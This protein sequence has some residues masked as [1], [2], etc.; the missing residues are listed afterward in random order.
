MDPIQAL[1]DGVLWPAVLAGV[2]ALVLR[3]LWR[4]EPSWP[5]A[6]GVAIAAAFALAFTLILGWPAFLP[7]DV[8]QVVPYVAVALGAVGFLARGRGL[9]TA[10]IGIATGLYLAWP[11]ADAGAIALHTGLVAATFVVLERGLDRV[12]TTLAPR[13]ANA[14]SL[15]VVSGAALAILFSD[16]ASL[17]QTTGA[18][19]AGLGALFTLGLWRPAAADITRAAP[20][21]AGVLATNLWST[22]LYANGRPEVIALIALAPWVV[23]LLVR[24]SGPRLVA[25]I[26]PALIVTVPIAIAATIAGMRYFAEPTPVEAAPATPGAKA[27]DYDPSY[28]Y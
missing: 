23:A 28:G 11:R 9:A 22:T 21:L 27:D 4:A 7:V 1:L 20:V 15:V 3:R 10:V 25:I 14:V 18:L 16:T 6:A 2:I 26:K 17:A 19:A 24:S 8:T 5:A 12:A 13:T